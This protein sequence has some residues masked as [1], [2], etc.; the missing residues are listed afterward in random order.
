[1]RTESAPKL[2]YTGVNPIGSATS[3]GITLASFLGAWPDP[4]LYQLFLRASEVDRPRGT[5]RLMPQSTYPA[6]YLARRILGGRTFSAN[7][8]LMH[9]AVAFDKSERTLATRLKL[10]ARDVNDLGFVHIGRQLRHDIESFAPEV[11]HSLLG[12]I[13]EMRIALALSRRFDVPILPHF[14]DDWPETIYSDGQLFGASRVEAQR[15]LREILKRSPVVLTIGRD[16]AAEYATRY[17]KETVA[18]GNCVDP[19]RSSS[20]D[21]PSNS[22]VYSG[23]LHLGRDKVVREI[24]HIIETEPGLHGVSIDLYTGASDA[25]HASDLERSHPSIRARG[26]LPADGIVSALAASRGAI[27]VESS[28]A[29]ILSYTRLSVSTKVPEYLASMVP[30][31]VVGPPG[32]SSVRELVRAPQALYGGDGS[33]TVRLAQ[34]VRALTAKR[35]QYAQAAEFPAWYSHAST[36]QRFTLAV[37]KSASSWRAAHPL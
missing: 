27:F 11:V 4:S 10:V 33:D 12:T 2:L 9:N 26:T 25:A 5:M 3:S 32:Q 24:A 36:S 15:L 8:H 13:R 34:A 6:N 7:H 18:V 20:A 14:T 1:M 29:E 28:N 19:L 21:R 23:G 22:L 16:M 37:Q 30:I 31:L 17:G 35:D